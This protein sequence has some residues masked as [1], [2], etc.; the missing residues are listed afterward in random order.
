MAVARRTEACRR[1]LFVTLGRRFLAW[2]RGRV[3]VLVVVLGALKVVVVVVG[4]VVVVAGGV[5]AL[6][7]VWPPH[8][9]SK[10]NAEVAS[11][12]ATR[13]PPRGPVIFRLRYY[14][15]PVR[16]NTGRGSSLSLGTMTHGR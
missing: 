16:G 14:R 7:R 3:V 12:T 1:L 8:A 13:R 9:P 15:T 4:L 11:A 10:T 6:G 2:G 5:V